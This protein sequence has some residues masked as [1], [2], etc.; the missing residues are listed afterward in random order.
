MVE[1]FNGDKELP[2]QS[3]SL[4][5]GNIE[6]TKRVTSDMHSAN[7][8]VDLTSGITCIEIS[9]KQAANAKPIGTGWVYVQRKGKADEANVKKY[10]PFI[11]NKLLR[12]N[13]REVIDP[14]N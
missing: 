4:Q 11:P 6:S 9:F 5:V 12:E 1:N 7:F 2:L 10:I 8:V 3:A 13:F 14:Y